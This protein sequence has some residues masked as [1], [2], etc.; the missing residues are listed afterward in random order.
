MAAFNA[1]RFKISS[2]LGGYPLHASL[3]T[4]NYTDLH[5][6]THDEIKDLQYVLDRMANAMRA[7]LPGDRRHEMT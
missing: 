7:A 1:G 2:G 3:Q 6:L 4:E 5:S